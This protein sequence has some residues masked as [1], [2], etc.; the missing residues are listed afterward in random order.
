VLLEAGRSARST[1]VLPATGLLRVGDPEV[2]EAFVQFAPKALD[3]T[4]WDKHGVDIVSFADQGRVL[5]GRLTPE[6]RQLLADRVGVEQVRS[7]PE[8]GA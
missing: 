5:Y 6:Q 2:W 4:V 3:G 8:R 1:G 7:S